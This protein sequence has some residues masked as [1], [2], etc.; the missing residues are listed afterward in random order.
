MLTPSPN[1]QNPARVRSFAY[2]VRAFPFLR[3]LTM[4]GSNAVT[5]KLPLYLIGE[6]RNFT[7]GCDWR[8][9]TIIVRTF[10][11]AE[12]FLAVSPRLAPG[13]ALLDLDAL[14]D[15][16]SALV[17]LR[18]RGSIRALL[19]QTSA[20]N[21]ET[22]VMAMRAGATDVLA[23]PYSSECLQSALEK[24]AALESSV[25][26]G[27]PVRSIAELSTREREV[28]AGLVRGLT[29]K[30]IGLELGISHR[31]VEIHRAR[32]MRKLGAASLSALLDIIF[33]QRDLLPE[34]P[35]QGVNL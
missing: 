15:P 2:A 5:G 31:T 9:S 17:R 18:R 20:H 32:L 6:G 12:A 7:V 13:I 30:Q 10:P 24:A 11:N 19:V 21:L 27:R 4:K 22:G 33:P 35:P 1:T 8:A 28:A 29:N 3:F 14:P 16:M 34:R 26:R 25:K 23:K